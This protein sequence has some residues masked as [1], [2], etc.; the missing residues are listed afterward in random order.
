M[1]EHYD[2]ETLQISRRLY[3]KIRAWATRGGVT[4]IGGWAVH[5]HVK[6]PMAH[7]SLATLT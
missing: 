5:E 1:T 6:P 2:F 3:E 4:L 7:N